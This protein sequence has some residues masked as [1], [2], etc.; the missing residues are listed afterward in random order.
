[1]SETGLLSSVFTGRQYGTRRQ[2]PADC[3]Y[4]IIY[5][6]LEPLSLHIGIP[7]DL[8]DTC[9]AGLR[10]LTAPTTDPRSQELLKTVLQHVITF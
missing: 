5:T 8:A 10:I 6:H 4:P 1:M 3:Q 9:A 7:S 2:M